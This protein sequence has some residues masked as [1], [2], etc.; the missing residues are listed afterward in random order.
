MEEGQTVDQADIIHSRG[1]A[2]Q[3]KNFIDNCESVLLSRMKEIAGGTL[4]SE[5]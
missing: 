1:K 2:G 3:T 5:K 4:G